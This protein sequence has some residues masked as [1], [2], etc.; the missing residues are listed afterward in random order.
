LSQRLS[1]A[2]RALVEAYRQ[3]LGPH[4][5]ARF[6]HVQLRHDA[7]SAAARVDDEIERMQRSGALKSVNRSYRDYRLQA[8]TRGERV[9]TYAAWMIRYKA[10]LIR[11]IAANLR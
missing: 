4:A 10:S 2:Q 3:G 8:C 11:E 6:S 1:N 9:M 5:A 7:L